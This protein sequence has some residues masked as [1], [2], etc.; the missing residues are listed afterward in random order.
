MGTLYL[1]SRKIG[2]FNR[3]WMPT[4]RIYILQAMQHVLIPRFI[5]SGR[6]LTPFRC[7][8]LLKFVRKVQQQLDFHRVNSVIYTGGMEQREIRSTCQRNMPVADILKY[9]LK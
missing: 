6:F 7:R 9:Y 8:T 4:V 5:R 3:V 1:A 2:R